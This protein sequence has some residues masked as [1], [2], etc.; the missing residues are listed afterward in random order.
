MPFAAP[1]RQGISAKRRGHSRG[2]DGRRPRGELPD[3]RPDQPIAFREPPPAPQPSRVELL[4]QP[5]C[6]LGLELGQDPL[7]PRVIVHASDTTETRS[8]NRRGS[9]DS[10]TRPP[11]AKTRHCAQRP[12]AVGG[13]APFGS[14][15]P[16]PLG[17]PCSVSDPSQSGMGRVC[18][19][20]PAVRDFV[21]VSLE[22][23]VF[24]RGGPFQGCDPIRSA[25]RPTPLITE[26][27]R[28][29]MP[30]RPR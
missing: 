12:N 4:P 19:D 20:R 17:P 24:P 3:D 18:A 9:D 22:T 15:T 25:S 29:D 8:K 14:E 10:A 2:R 30:L 23:S 1:A 16:I 28:L 27:R 26:R 5:G 6:V 11:Y 21:T 13:S 7:A